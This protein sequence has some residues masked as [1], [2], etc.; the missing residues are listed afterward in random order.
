MSRCPDARAAEAVMD[1]VLAK[2]HPIANIRLIYISEVVNSTKE[3]RYGVT[4]K[5]GDQECA[6]DAQQ[7]CAQYWSRQA[8]AEAGLDPWTR[9]W[10]FIKCQN[11]EYEDVGKFALADKC[12]DESGFTG[13][14]ANLTKTCWSGP[15]VVPLLRNSAREAVRRRASVSATV[16]VNG[17]YRCTRDDGQ[18]LDCPGGSEVDDFVYTVCDTYRH[19]GRQWPEAVC[20]PEPN[21]PPE[22][23]S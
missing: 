8:P 22:T 17:E 23:D 11:R 19:W 2:V 9:A 12:L 14:R 10:D 1:Q 6:G 13:K 15:D 20:G 3:A 7:L 4:C 16:F 5:H 18:W 21:P